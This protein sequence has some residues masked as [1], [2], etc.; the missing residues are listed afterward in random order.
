[1]LGGLLGR[2]KRRRVLVEAGH[3]R[4]HACQVWGRQGLRATFPGDP[5]KQHALPGYGRVWGTDL[6]DERP[7][8]RRDGLGHDQVRVAPKR[9]QPLQFFGQS[10]GTVP[11]WRTQ[12]QGI[13]GTVGYRDV[14][15]RIRRFRHQG[16]RCPME[17]VAGQD[18][19]GQGEQIVETGDVTY[20]ST[21][22]AP[23]EGMVN[24]LGVR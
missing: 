9:Q 21:Y 7:I 16:E 1:M 13:R 10:L 19:L 4:P 6:L 5:V 11:P 22:L 2:N 3:T 14:E 23:H 15:D 12:A 17:V 18:T 20:H 8:T 24:F